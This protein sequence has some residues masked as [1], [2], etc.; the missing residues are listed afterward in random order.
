MQVL[1][2]L[3]VSHILSISQFAGVA[4]ALSIVLLQAAVILLVGAVSIFAFAI[5]QSYAL[6][7]GLNGLFHFCWNAGQPL[8]LGIIASR[9]TGGEGGFCGSPYRYNIL[10]WRLAQ[11]LRLPNLGQTAIILR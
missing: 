10:V 5:D 1:T 2:S 7:L 4:G 6:F 8:L 9:D 3:A 11:L